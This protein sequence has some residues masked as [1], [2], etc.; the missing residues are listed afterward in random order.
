MAGLGDGALEP[1]AVLVEWDGKV[2]AGFS[3]VSSTGSERE[4][5]EIREGTD[6]QDARRS[7]RSTSSNRVKLKRG[8]VRSPALFE[9]V[10]AVRS[11]SPERRDMVITVL[12]ERGRPAERWRLAQ[13]WITKFEA[14]ELNAEGNDVAIET[15]TFDHEGLTLEETDDPD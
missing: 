4:V 14:P 10:R 9:W 13:A 12:D 3:E 11:G 6:P 1:Y 5:V 7:T 15:L 2:V 8:V